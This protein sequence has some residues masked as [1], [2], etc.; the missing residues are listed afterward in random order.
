[1]YIHVLLHQAKAKRAAASLNTDTTIYIP[2]NRALYTYLAEHKTSTQPF[3]L[4]PS[5]LAPEAFISH[6]PISLLHPATSIRRSRTEDRRHERHL[7]LIFAAT[8]FHRVRPASYIFSAPRS[9]FE[10]E[11]PFALLQ[12]KMAVSDLK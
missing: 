10:A 3:F 12:F 4:C 9:K 11:I 1:M 2:V 5:L 7:R 8:A 6:I